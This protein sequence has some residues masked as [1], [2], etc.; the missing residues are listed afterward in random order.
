MKPA[1]WQQMPLHWSVLR[2]NNAQK[3]RVSPVKRDSYILLISVGYHPGVKLTLPHFCQHN[4][5]QIQ[6]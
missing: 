1:S 2:R 5:E 4:T 6:D 3:N